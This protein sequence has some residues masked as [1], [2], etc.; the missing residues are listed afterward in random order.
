VIATQNPLDLS[1]T[2]P[3]PVA[4]LDRFLF[5]IKMDFIDRD[6]EIAVLNTRMQRAAGSSFE[7]AQVARGAVVKARQAV[8]QG[9]YLHP[10][11]NAAL[12]DLARAVRGHSQVLQGIS[13]RSLVL[14]APALQ[15]AALLR[16]RDFVSEDDIRWLAPYV[17][18][19]R[20]ALAPGAGD[21][22]K[23][24]HEA[25]TPVLDQLSKGT[26]KP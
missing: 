18:C 7:G 16:G 6:S 3:L 2:Y 26:L 11:I 4:Q 17:F 14:M 19:H 20:M 13:T 21:A 10:K 22:E 15:A 5:K 23:I 8:A 25:I 9:V 1:G 24:L 12:V